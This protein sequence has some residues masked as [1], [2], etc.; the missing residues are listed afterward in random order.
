MGFVIPLTATAVPFY[1]N[2]Y[3]SICVPSLKSSTSVQMWISTCVHVCLIE[4]LNH[5]LS[6]G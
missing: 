5:D 4:A 2:I 6:R 3:Y 1:Y